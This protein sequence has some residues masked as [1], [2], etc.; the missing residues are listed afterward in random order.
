MMTQ[1][2]LRDYLAKRRA[3]R[4]YHI[5][6][7]TRR[8]VVSGGPTLRDR[9]SGEPRLKPSL[10]T[11]TERYRIRNALLDLAT[12]L[13]DYE[14]LEALAER[15]KISRPELRLILD[16]RYRKEYAAEGAPELA[17]TDWY[18]DTSANNPV[19]RPVVS[20]QEYQDRRALKEARRRYLDAIFGTRGKGGA[21]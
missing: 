5:S 6:R 20:L 18:P 13:P 16:Q 19:N 14:E 10:A 3:A 9:L 4:R 12:P 7:P 2:E 8:E 21:A 11:A 1:E 15:A 17:N